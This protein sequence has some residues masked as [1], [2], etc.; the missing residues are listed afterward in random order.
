MQEQKVSVIIPTLWRSDATVPLINTLLDWPLLGE[1]IIIDNAP[2]SRPHHSC[3]GDCTI[4]A[5]EENIYVNPAWN[6]GVRHAKEDVIA[7]C[8][9]DICF[10]PSDLDHFIGQ[11]KTN[12][13]LGL[14]EDSILKPESIN[15]PELRNGFIMGLGWGC[16]MLMRKSA[17]IP[18]PG[19]IRVW[20]GD[21]WLVHC[22]N[23][24]KSIRIRV[25]GTLSVS[26]SDKKFN[27][28]KEED[29][30]HYSKLIWH[31]LYRGLRIL[32]RSG[33]KYPL[34]QALRLKKS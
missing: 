13:I 30:I 29:Q 28:I 9:D 23:V 19:N 5:Q 27:P 12:E 15:Q 17:Y 3:F 11:L 18:I 4:L 14:H 10:N 24:K 32:C 22:T 1:L 7:I 33:L 2:S 16:L 26:A 6:L 20:Y 34:K 21:D 31:P 25:E 8:N